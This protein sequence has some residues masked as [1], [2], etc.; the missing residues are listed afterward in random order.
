MNKETNTKTH[1]YQNSRFDKNFNNPLKFKI[2]EKIYEKPL[3]S[4]ALKEF[5]SPDKNDTAVILIYPISLLLNPQVKSWNLPTDF[6]EKLFKL[7]ESPEEK[8][9]YLKK[10]N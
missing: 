8:E 7:L 6:K 4:F 9:N 10:S 5:L 3:S 2:K 1:I